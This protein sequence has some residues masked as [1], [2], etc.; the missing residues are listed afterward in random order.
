MRS[1][2][3]TGGLS[4]VV[5]IYDDDDDTYTYVYVLSGSRLGNIVICV[6]VLF[7]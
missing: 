4:V 1:T 5:C 7:T 3:T 2:Y 6:D